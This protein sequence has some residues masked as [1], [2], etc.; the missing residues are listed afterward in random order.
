[1]KSFIVNLPLL[2][3]DLIH[4]FCHCLLFFYQLRNLSPQAGLPSKLY[5]RMSPRSLLKM[6]HSLDD[7]SDMLLCITGLTQC[8]GHQTITRVTVHGP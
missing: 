1:M 4:V 5:P 7:H 2:V 6:T 3:N 8:Q